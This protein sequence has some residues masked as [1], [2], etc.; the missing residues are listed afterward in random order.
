MVT[1]SNPT[2]NPPVHGNSFSVTASGGTADYTFTWYIGE[3]Q[4]RSITQSSPT[5]SINL[6]DETEGKMLN[7][8][9]KDGNNDRASDGWL[10][11]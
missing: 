5:F 2:P 7:V 8:R 10:I 9:V 1:L 4:E 11:T 6:G 3:G